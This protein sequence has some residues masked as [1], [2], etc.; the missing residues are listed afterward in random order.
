MEK[1]CQ[2]AYEAY[3]QDT[4][5]GYLSYADFKKKLCACLPWWVYAAGGA[6]VGYAIKK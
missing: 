3:R 4:P 2:I 1:Y 5:T 6:A